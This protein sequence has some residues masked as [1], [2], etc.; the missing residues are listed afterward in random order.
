M[1]AAVSPTFI[2]KQTNENFIQDS[3]LTQLNKHQPHTYI[4][5]T[6]TVLFTAYSLENM[7]KQA[8]LQY[9]AC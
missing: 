2:C 3:L 4:S 6:I 1:T 7:G 5:F 8:N 9:V